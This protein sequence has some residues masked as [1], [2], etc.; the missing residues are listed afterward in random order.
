VGD[1]TVLALW[2]EPLQF[3]GK[4]IF[5][6]VGRERPGCRIFA[7]GTPDY[8]VTPTGANYGDP[9]VRR[10]AIERANAILADVAVARGVPFVD[11]WAASRAAATD[12]SLVADDGLHPSGRQYASWVDAIEPVVRR[13]L[14]KTLAKT[15]ARPRAEPASRSRHAEEPT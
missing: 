11:V 5:D 3:Q 15:L 10:A 1:D 13:L 9:A 6:G 4:V 2:Q 7:V 14:A 8:T 12:P